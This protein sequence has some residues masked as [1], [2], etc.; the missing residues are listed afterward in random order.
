MTPHQVARV[1]P[2]FHPLWADAGPD[3][4]AF[5]DSHAGTATSGPAPRSPP[6]PCALGRLGRDRVDEEAQAGI[7][8]DRTSTPG[9]GRRRV[10]R[11]RAHRLR[12]RLHRELVLRHPTR[13]PT[14]RRH[15]PDLLR[16][17]LQRAHRAGRRFRHRAAPGDH[18]R[19]LR[20]QRPASVF[21]HGHQS[22]RV[23]DK[24]SGRR[25]A[26]A[27]L[28][29]S[30]HGDRTGTGKATADFCRAPWIRLAP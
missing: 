27:D 20:S 1:I 8:V 13:L 29:R 16:E 12:A 24:E 3:T 30:A 18:P 21:L 7:G 15:R 17:D 19:C 14:R 22:V 26:R 25:R 2:A 23:P 28:N 5:A 4:I 10:Q 11:A 9:Y 6:T